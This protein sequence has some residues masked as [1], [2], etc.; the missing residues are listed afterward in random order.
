M[1][2]K[3]VKHAHYTHWL[4]K[5]VFRVMS[6]KRILVRQGGGREV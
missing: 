6:Q 5:I 1:E 4:W 2:K 3:T